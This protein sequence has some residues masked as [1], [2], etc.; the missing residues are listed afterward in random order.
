MNVPESQVKPEAGLTALEAVQ[1]QLG[2]L[3]DNDQPWPNHGL[4][5]MYD[6]GLDI[7]GMERSQYFGFSKDLYH[8]EC[9]LPP[10][11]AAGNL[12]PL[13]TLTGCL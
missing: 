12:R 13:H 4:L 11:A 2:A 8:F 7:G 10:A 9:A 5:T 1:A 3:V 6:W